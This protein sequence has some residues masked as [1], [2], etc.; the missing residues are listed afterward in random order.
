LSG[1]LHVCKLVCYQGI[2]FSETRL[3]FTPPAS[4]STDVQ[5]LVPMDFTGCT[6]R[7]MVRT[8]EDPAAT[9]LL[10]L[11]TGSGLTFV[12]QTFTPG[13]PLP[14][15]NNGITIVITRAQSLAMNSGVPLLGAYYD[16]FVDQPGGTTI[17]LMKGQ[18]DL[19]A[20]GTR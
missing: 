11:A 14:S 17:L 8:T 19:A 6:A 3:F 7:M 15:A 4:G 10:S 12:A 13:P 16:L 1:P 9:L 2:D 20:T 18:F 5:Q